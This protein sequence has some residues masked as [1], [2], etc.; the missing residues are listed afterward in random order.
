MGQSVTKIDVNVASQE[1]K[2][3]A[4]CVVL[5]L[6]INLLCKLQVNERLVFMFGTLGK[7]ALD[8]HF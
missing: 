8:R 5:D 4:D 7:L 1:A 2:R 6:V 3:C